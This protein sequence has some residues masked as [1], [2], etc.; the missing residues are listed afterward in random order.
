MSKSVGNANEAKPAL[1][2]YSQTIARVLA[3]THP[4]RSKHMRTTN[5]SPVRKDEAIMTNLPGACAR[6]VS[7]LGVSR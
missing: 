6:R 3:S 4:L 1:V 2:R 7:P 5:H